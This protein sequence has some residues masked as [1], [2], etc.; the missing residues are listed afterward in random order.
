MVGNEF[1]Q[2][3]KGANESPECQPGCTIRSQE[4]SNISQLM[5][6]G[7]EIADQIKTTIK[8]LHRRADVVMGNI[9]D[10]TGHADQTVRTINPNIQTIAANGAK[11]STNTNK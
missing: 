10:L 1:V 7:N 11:I 6:Q 2:V 4:P 3:K 5:Q 9:S 8:D